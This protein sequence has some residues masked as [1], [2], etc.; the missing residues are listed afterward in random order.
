MF[1][2]H[3]HLALDRSDSNVNNGMYLET[4]E[5]NTGDEAKINAPLSILR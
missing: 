4:S 3:Q 1:W 5:K 2:E